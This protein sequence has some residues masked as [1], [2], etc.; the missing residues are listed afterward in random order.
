M[1][2]EDYSEPVHTHWTHS[3]SPHVRGAH[4]TQDASRRVVV[5]SSRG[6]ANNEL[7]IY[8]YGYR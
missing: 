5:L 4:I 7:I 3:K 6:T 8:L 2:S 1:P